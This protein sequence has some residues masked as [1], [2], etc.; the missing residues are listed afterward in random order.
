[1][2]YTCTIICILFAGS[3]AVFKCKVAGEPTPKVTWSKGQKILKTTA[4]KNVEITYNKDTDEHVIVMK[5]T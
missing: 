3:T 1:M 2:E 5:G 4:D